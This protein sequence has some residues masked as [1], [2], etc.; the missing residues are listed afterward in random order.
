MARV[1]FALFILLLT[2]TAG[3]PNAWGLQVDQGSG[4]VKDP[5][6]SNLVDPDE[7]DPPFMLA[8]QDQSP[9]RQQNTSS[10]VII[11]QNAQREK[12]YGLSQGFDKAYSNK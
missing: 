3:M 12:A 8:P 10:S 4:G 7:K 2:L 1:Y 6:T 5:N 9:Q 11:D